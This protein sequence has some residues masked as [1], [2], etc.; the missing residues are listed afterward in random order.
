M[1]GAR[2]LLILLWGYCSNVCWWNTRLASILPLIRAIPSDKWDNGCKVLSLPL[3]QCLHTRTKTMETLLSFRI[4]ANRDPHLIWPCLEPF[5][6]SQKLFFGSSIRLFFSKFNKIFITCLADTK[7]SKNQ[8][9]AFIKAVVVLNKHTKLSY[10][11]S[12]SISVL[13]IGFGSFLSFESQLGPNNSLG[14]TDKQRTAVHRFPDLY[15]IHS[16]LI[17]VC[18]QTA[19]KFKNRKI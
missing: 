16:Y 2:V 7:K 11:K 17:D 5:L 10:W 18:Y 14:D 12:T 8:L 15:F 6:K 4:I 3:M 1:E 13:P 19:T 9:H